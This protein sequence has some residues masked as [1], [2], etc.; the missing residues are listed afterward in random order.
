VYALAADDGRIQHQSTTSSE[1]APL[2]LEILEI[3]LE[4]VPLFIS[5]SHSLWSFSFV[6]RLQMIV[7][8]METNCQFGLSC[9]WNNLFKRGR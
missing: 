5:I 2:A 9:S 6:F 4:S 7:Q 8:S 3:I 1:P